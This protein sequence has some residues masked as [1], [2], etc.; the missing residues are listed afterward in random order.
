[1]R[2]PTDLIEDEPLDP[3]CQALES[4]RGRLETEA[5]H[6]PPTE[7]MQTPAQK[8]GGL[9]GPLLRGALAGG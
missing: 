3:T 9:P 6:V 4:E 1:M 7:G 2:E 8:E 5:A